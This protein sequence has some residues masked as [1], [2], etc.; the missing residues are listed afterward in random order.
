MNAN[1]KFRN[2]DVSL[3]AG[4]ETNKEKATGISFGTG[5][6]LNPDIYRLSN[7]S[8]TPSVSQLKPN[9]SELSSV[10]FQGGASWRNFLS[11]NIYGRND[12]NLYSG[13]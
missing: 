1:R 6:G 10:Y 4:A 5:A 9:I 3:Q 2:W 7:S 13:L 12:W 11:F 8:S